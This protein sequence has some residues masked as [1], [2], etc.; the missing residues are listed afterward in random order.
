MSLQASFHRIGTP[1]TR[2]CCPLVSLETRAQEKRRQHHQ[3]LLRAAV[4]SPTRSHHRCGVQNLQPSPSV[5]A[6][7][8]QRPSR[9]G[10]VTLSMTGSG[11][12]R[13]SPASKSSSELKNVRQGG[14]KAP[15]VTAERG[16]ALLQNLQK[17]GNGRV[18]P[19]FS[20]SLENLGLRPSR[21]PVRRSSVLHPQSL[22]RIPKERESPLLRVWKYSADPIV[23]Q[24]E[25]A[26]LAA[27]ASSLTVRS[28]P[29]LRSK[30][31]EALFICEPTKEI[32]DQSFALVS[33]EAARLSP[34][35][36]VLSVCSEAE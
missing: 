13:S 5:A 29:M 4:H 34:Y 10:P 16:M 14:P 1:R 21:I 23:K 20:R 24:R 28:V 26:D 36:S 9:S 15:Q 19:G 25:L 27:V 6:S 22:L 33:P 12:S 18:E 7:T 11:L 8:H 30:A 35:Q 3:S 32:N 31:E 2:L 17:R